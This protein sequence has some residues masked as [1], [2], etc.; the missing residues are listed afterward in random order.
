[1]TNIFI[2]MIQCPFFHNYL[3]RKNSVIFIH[4]SK[5]FKSRSFYFQYIIWKNVYIKN[6][7]VIN[8]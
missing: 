6:I 1:M 8:L 7:A 3:V 2:L 4:E 5:I